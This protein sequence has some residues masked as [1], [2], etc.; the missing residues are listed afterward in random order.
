ME[1][2]YIVALLT[3]TAMVC[4]LCAPIIFIKAT[5]IAVIIVLTIIFIYVLM[6]LMIIVTIL[7]KKTVKGS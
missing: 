6:I 3:A 5:F 2:I 7:L 4:L 1:P